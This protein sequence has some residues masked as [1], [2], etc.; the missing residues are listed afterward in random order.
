M[1]ERDPNTAWAL[2]AGL[3]WLF[4]VGWFHLGL[5]PMGLARLGVE[6]V[7]G[8]LLT[9]YTAVRHKP[10][11]EIRQEKRGPI[12]LLGFGALTSIGHVAFWII[13]TDFLAQFGSKQARESTK[14]HKDKGEADVVILADLAAE[15]MRITANTFSEDNCAIVEGCIDGPGERRL[16]RWDEVI[17]NKGEGDFV[18]GLESQL[19]PVWSP[20]H[21]HYHGQN[22][23]SHFLKRE[24]LDASNNTVRQIYHGHKAGYCYLDSRRISGSY[25]NKFDCGSPQFTRDLLQGITSGWADV[26]GSE[27]D[28]QWIDITG[29][30]AGTY[31]LVLTINPLG[32][33]YQDKNLTNNRGIVEVVIPPMDGSKERIRHGVYVNATVLSGEVVPNI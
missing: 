32:I 29:L 11:T 28:C 30:P 14:W 17:Y 3:G 13:Q 24:L 21:Q 10:I 1:G 20:C 15:S 6:V 8:S 33:Y 26:Y 25:E 5:W 12:W 31:Q 2:E 18:K 9:L 16:L 7:A 19:T 4:P 23:A 27:T 22:T